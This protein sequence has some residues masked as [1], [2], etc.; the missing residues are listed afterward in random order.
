MDALVSVVGP[1]LR[2]RHGGDEAIQNEVEEGEDDLRDVG[3]E[4]R[5]N[6]TPFA[7]RGDAPTCD[8]IVRGNDANA[9][10]YE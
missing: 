4:H 8:E 9:E 10:R 5:A 3:Y 7:A 1:L 6:D 2:G